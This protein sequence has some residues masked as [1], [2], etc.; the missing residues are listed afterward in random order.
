LIEKKRKK[1]NAQDKNKTCW[2]V[3]REK[4]RKKENAQDENKTCCPVGLSCEFV[5]WSDDTGGG[6]VKSER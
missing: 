4:K 3:L 2:P 6:G 1:E 5:K